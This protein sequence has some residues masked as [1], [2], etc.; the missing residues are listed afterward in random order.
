[1]QT[2]KTLVKAGTTGYSAANGGRVFHV[3]SSD[4]G[5]VLSITLSDASG[6][7]YSV[8]DVG[9][10]FKAVPMAGFT[11]VSITATADS[12]VAFIV[13]QGDVDIQLNEVNAI[14]GNTAAS[15]AN[16]QVQGQGTTA[17]NPLYVNA[18]GVTLEATN[19]GISNTAANPV[20]VSL[21][22]EPGA[23]MAVN[24]TVN[25]GNALGAPVPTL[26]QPIATGV[27][28]AA[29]V[30]VGTTNPSAALV[31]ASGARKGFRVLNAGTGKLAITASAA[32]TLANAALVLNPGDM[33]DETEAPGAAW[34]A[35]SDTGT[36][37]NVQVI[38]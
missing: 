37:A 24:G 7:N 17:G 31:A 30:A 36:T 2:I 32:T 38:A 15:P 10:G 11:Q 4:A 21:V 25:I 12:N 5:D 20:P 33:W 16:V 26:A 28:D 19:V 18:S 23:P 13:S 3:Q 1:M 14:I 9:A 27:T 34:F 29:P 6:N 22:S 8:S 35:I